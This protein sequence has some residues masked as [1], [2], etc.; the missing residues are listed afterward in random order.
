MQAH[1][2][3]YAGTLDS[4]REITKGIRGYKI[5]GLYLHWPID[6]KKR[7]TI[8]IVIIVLI[9]GC[10]LYYK[11]GLF[12]RYNFVTAYWDSWTDKERI[13]VFGEMNQHD[14]LKSKI[15]PDYGFAYE[16]GGGCLVT[17]PL[18]NG[19]EDYNAIMGSRINSRLGKNWE[20]VLQRNFKNRVNPQ[21]QIIFTFP[22]SPRASRGTLRRIEVH[23]PNPSRAQSKI[24]NTF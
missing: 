5:Y 18:L 19:L 14:I 3:H 22:Q 17:A 8:G 10:I 4:Y 15:A 20:D 9:A 6:M 11:F 13:V 24:P 2:G 21:R 1:N 23:P 7:T 12:E 16:I